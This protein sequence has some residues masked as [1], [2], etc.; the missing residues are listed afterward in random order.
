MSVVK[1]KIP[2]NSGCCGNEGKMPAASSRSKIAA[3]S[4]GTGCC[5]GHITDEKEKSRT[6]PDAIGRTVPNAI[7]RTVPSASWD[8]GCVSTPVG[9]VQ[10]V[11]TILK[12]SDIL[13]SVKARIGVG[14]S[15]YRIAP[16]IYCTGNPDETSPVLVTANYKMTFDSLRIELSGLNTWI[17]VLDTKG[18]N[19]WCAAGKGTFGTNELIDK[20]SMVNL[21]SIVS[22]RNVILPQLGAAGV[23]AH[24]IKKASGFNVIYGPVR[25]SDLKTFIQ[26]GMIADSDMRTVKFNVID[27]LVL[28]PLELINTVQPL[29]VVL[30]VLFILNAVGV[31]DFGVMDVYLITGALFVGTVLT[32]VLLPI[33]PGR[34]FSLKGW[35]LGLLWVISMLLLNSSSDI[36]SF[37]WQKAVAFLLALPTISSYLAM[38]FTGCSTYTSF[39]GVK[40]E[41]KIALPILLILLTSGIVFFIID[42]IFK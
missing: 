12:F 36:A 1:I 41:M 10:R 30:G 37:S 28:T 39:S 20:I 22:H 33:I 8:E 35:L 29:L 25:A 40:R 27:R 18:I 7:G 14:R 23:S 32:P 11:S 31:G 42:M 4:T 15:N 17:L 5:N 26:N 9:P 16:G 19:V 6:V 2:S 3:C 38:N 21:S 34:A 13:G 24:I